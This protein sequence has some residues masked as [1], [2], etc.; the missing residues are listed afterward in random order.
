MAGPRGETPAI[1]W[2]SGTMISIIIPTYQHAEALRA[3]LASIAEQTFLDYEVIVVD[4]G[5]TDN[6]EEVVQSAP[7]KAM[8]IK[9]ENGGA[10][11]ARNRGFAESKGEF[12]IFCDAD[13]VLRPDCLEK[14]HTALATPPASPPAFVY[15]SFRFGW[16]KF[17]LFPFDVEK[18]KK[19][20][21]IHSTSLVRRSHMVPWDES[22][23][24]LQDWD[25]FLT[26]VEHGGTGVWIPEVL[27]TVT[28][29]REGMSE[30]VP[31][32][33]YT[34]LGKF[35]GL[36]QTAVD[37]YEQAHAIIV[38]KHSLDCHPEPFD[39]A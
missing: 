16:K 38:K 35:F 6:T 2:N 34:P 15:S 31:R 1:F 27:F 18:L 36:W 17:E 3:C 12:V 10:P 25:F 23:K 9:Q 24:R 21:Y 37:K 4:D 22:L 11:K 39:S 28:K 29:T 8:Y 26:I 5:S 32:I 19:R 33:A 30:W 13:V 20:N 7:M 14:M